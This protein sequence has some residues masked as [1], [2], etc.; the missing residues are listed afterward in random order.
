[1]YLRKM[2]ENDLDI[3]EQLKGDY[4]KYETEEY[5]IEYNECDKEY[6]NELIKYFEQEK[7]NKIKWF[8]R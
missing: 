3:L 8:C 6:I 5:I 2:N 7:S 4:M 1:M